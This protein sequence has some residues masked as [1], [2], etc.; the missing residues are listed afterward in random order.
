MKNHVVID[1][2]FF[3]DSSLL[4]LNF[5]VVCDKTRDEYKTQTKAT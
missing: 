3:A 4:C 2:A 1:F 5:V